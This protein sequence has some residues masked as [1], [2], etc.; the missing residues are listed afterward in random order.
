MKYAGRR[1]SD[2]FAKLSGMVIATIFWERVVSD[3]SGR[4][5]SRLAI[6]EA[7]NRL[8]LSAE[9]KDVRVSDIVREADI[10]RS[11]FYEHFPNAQS[12]FAEAISRP[13]KIF[14]EASLQQN[15]NRLLEMVEHFGEQ[16]IQA[17]T[18]FMD[19]RSRDQVVSVMAT[20]YEKLLAEQ[21]AEV[22]NRKW[23]ALTLAES[24]LAMVRQWIDGKLDVEACRLV[25]L[26]VACTDQ[27]RKIVAK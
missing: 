14:A 10:G 1:I 25:E 11:T 8:V 27:I 19:A 17:R 22:D 16:R 6:I 18:I 3:E 12:V 2:T 5:K 20:E 15:L 9:G 26:I 21:V 23:L 13:F 24:N 7:F 4:P